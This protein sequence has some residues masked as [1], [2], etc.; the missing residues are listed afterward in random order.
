MLAA[1]IIPALRFPVPWWSIEPVNSRFGPEAAGLGNESAV[2][3]CVPS[4]ISRPR[5]RGGLSCLPMIA[6]MDVT[7]A[8]HAQS[9]CRFGLPPFENTAGRRIFVQGVM[10]AIFVVIV[11]V[12]SNEPRRW[13][14]LSTITWSSNSL[15]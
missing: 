3:C 8:R 4:K 12:L 15:R 5:K 10:G 6:M 13:D 1:I 9:F 7:D 14:S 2:F 11:E